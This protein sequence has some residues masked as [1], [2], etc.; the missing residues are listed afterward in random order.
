MALY[1]APGLLAA[2]GVKLRV[3]PA[4]VLPDAHRLLLAVTGSERVSL[5]PTPDWVPGGLGDHLTSFGGGLQG[6]HGQSSALD[7]IVS[8]VTA[9]H[10]AVSEPC[11][12][13]QK[14]PHPQVLLLHYLQGST[15]TLKPCSGL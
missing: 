6:A 12:H 9:N 7:W 1:P 5:E 10:G 3:A 11:N 15:A 8:G 14:F 13:A 4:S 2:L